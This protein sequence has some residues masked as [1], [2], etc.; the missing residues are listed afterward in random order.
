[1]RF[2]N[3]LAPVQKQSGKFVYINKKGQ[4]VSGE[5]DSAN[6]FYAG[7]AFVNQVSRPKY[8]S[9]IDTTFT[10]VRRTSEMYIPYEQAEMGYHFQDNV[11]S[12]RLGG[13]GCW[14]VSPDGKELIKGNYNE[15]MF[16][17]NSGL[18]HSQAFVGDQRY[19]GFINIKGEYI[20]IFKDEEF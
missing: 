10:E 17:Y 1:M 6:S 7:Y 13:D 19:D 11:A 8:T 16:G 15:A 9:V 2:A 5:Y 12:V 14:L 18:A 4:V 3:G 20:F